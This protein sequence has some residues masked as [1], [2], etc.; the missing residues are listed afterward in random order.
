MKNEVVADR[1]GMGEFSQ[2]TEEEKAKTSDDE[3]DSHDRA[4]YP[5]PSAENATQESVDDNE[6]HTHEAHRAD[7]KNI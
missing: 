6:P 7:E 1:A 5:G 3:T 2:P 4:R